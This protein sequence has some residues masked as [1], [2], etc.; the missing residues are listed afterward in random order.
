MEKDILIQNIREGNTVLGLELGSTRIKAV[1][2]GP[3]HAP[4]VS[5]SHD[6]ENRL[7]EGYWTYHL[8]DVWAGI[9]D[10]YANLAA[11]V[12]KEYGIPL[13][14]VKAMGFSA[15]MHGYLPFDRDG[16]QLAA[17]RT[18][19]NTTTGGAAAELTE[20]FGFNI[21]Q[22]WSVAHLYQ[23]IL[24]GEEHVKELSFFT[25]LAGYVHWRLTGEK[26]LGVGEA[27]G[28]FPIDS[29]TC[30]FDAGMK[31]KFNTLLKER[32]LPFCLD[33]ILPR[34]LPAGVPAGRLTPE[35]ARLLDPSGCLQPGIPLCPPEGDAGT[36]MTATNS[37]A[38]R[39]GNVSAGTSVFAMVVLERPLSRV[40]PEIDMVTTPT[41]RPVA[42]VHCNTC[43]SDLDAWVK[44]LGE[45]AGA[46]GAVL[47]KPQLYDLF[48]SKA[49]EGEPD[50][51]GLVNINY[52]SGEP[53]T[54]FEEGRPLFLRRP[55]ARLTLA[56]FARAQLYSTIA[57]LK[58]GMGLLL[59]Q[60]HVQLETLLGHGGLFKTA[61]VGQRLL[62]GAL[63]VPVAVMETA[64][65]GG[66]WG[67]ALLASYMA[68]REQAETLE[69][70]LASKVFAKTSCN[71]QQPHDDDTS[72][73][74]RFMENYKSALAV[75]RAAVAAL[76]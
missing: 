28:M 48:Y 27:S 23:A 4:L 34:V 73:F 24:N 75:E 70:Y 19:R 65:E 60:E 17:F 62:A 36:G 58:L 76:K 2:I 8:E 63:R 22:R 15:M 16:R 59:E 7:E 14:T 49:L 5:G 32:G 55:G 38:Q 20:I 21:P 51:G 54:G 39:T 31:A 37:V 67:M 46:S 30:D 18:W 47:S 12:K 72:G 26:V 42:M 11:A 43:T 35:G 13:C 9:Q 68:E 29:K 41:G 56:N 50:C 45:M 10:A 6:W 74:A 66:P 3:D 1:L 64:G 53:V 71:V 52:Y 69:S 57:T 61:E 33:D 40:Y 44:M 25:T